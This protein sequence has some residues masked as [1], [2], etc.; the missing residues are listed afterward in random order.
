LLAETLNAIGAHPMESLKHYLA[1]RRLGLVLGGGGA[2]GAYQL[3]CW[4]ALTECGLQPNI[5][6]L[7]GSSIGAVN[8]VLIAQDNYESFESFWNSFSREFRKLLHR[9]AIRAFVA[10]SARIVVHVSIVFY[11]ILFF[12]GLKLASES[13][14]RSVDIQTVTYGAITMG[15]SLI[16]LSF[17]VWYRR[18]LK[19]RFPILADQKME[20]ILKKFIDFNK[21]R[22]TAL[23]VYITHTVYR[24]LLNPPLEKRLLNTSLIRKIWWK[25]EQLEEGFYRRARDP[26]RY[27]LIPE[28]I[29]LTK[30]EETQFY[31]YLI[32]S[33]ALPEI[34]PET[35]TEH[36]RAVDGGIVDNLPVLPLLE[37]GSE[38]VIAITLDSKMTIGKLREEID[39]LTYLRSLLSHVEEDTAQLRQPNE[40]FSF[41]TNKLLLIRP[42]K[43]LGPFPIETLNVFS[44]RK[45]QRLMALGY[46]DAMT[47]L[48]AQIEPNQGT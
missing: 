40:H 30:L 17:S 39:K 2:K 35:A 9:I 31:Q 16:L 48:N 22:S 43:N 11:L 1:S 20:T 28:Y 4:K 21:F 12:Y 5:F 14:R 27:F 46:H 36:Y 25:F 47:L 44:I 33:C 18:F 8:A 6:A 37:N 41:D 3:G 7:S 15:L 13:T 32:R 26:R 45:S 29:D 23:P 38:A 10:I 34:F 19:R 42:S 24:E